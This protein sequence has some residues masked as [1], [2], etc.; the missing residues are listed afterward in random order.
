MPWGEGVRCLGAAGAIYPETIALLKANG[1]DHGDFPSSILRNLERFLPT[2]EEE[3]DAGANV[4]GSRWRIP[5]EEIRRRRDLRDKRIF[6]ID[7]T[8]A[9]DLDDALSVTPLADGT[10][11]VGVHIADVTYFVQPGSELDGE[12][13]RRATTV[14][15]VQQVSTAR[16]PNDNVKGYLEYSTGSLCTVNQL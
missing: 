11:E 7:P 4:R 16:Y 15:L 8:G 1:V 2:V 3:I 10:I 6:T 14:Y 9:R 5:Q 12:A 13:R